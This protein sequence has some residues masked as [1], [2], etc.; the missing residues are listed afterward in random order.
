[1]FDELG[2]YKHNGHFFFSKG[3]D[4]SE[5]A[6]QVPDRPG[7]YCIYRLSRGHVDIVY[8]GKSGVMQ[9]NGA[10]KGP[11]LHDSIMHKPDGTS[12]Q[13][14]YN[15]KMN[16]EQIDALDVYWYVTFDEAYRDLPSY[17]EARLIQRYFEIYGQLPPWNREY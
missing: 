2:T 13:A 5:V 15:R 16:A 17:V 11:M 7:V 12:R 10:F 6:G 4:L 14:Y 3:D 9:P 8:I 1:M